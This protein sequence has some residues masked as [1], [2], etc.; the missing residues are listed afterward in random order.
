MPGLRDRLAFYAHRMRQEGLWWAVTR[1]LKRAAYAA[2]WLLLLPLTLL[3]H[4]AGVRRLTVF[5]DRIGHLAAEIDAFLKEQALGRL[6]ARRWFVLAPPHRVANAALLDRWRA[7]LPVIDSP[8]LCLLL[9]IMTWNYW[10]MCRDIR[11]YVL[12][13]PGTAR[14]YEIEAAWGE[15][16]PLLALTPEDHAR[17]R[18][19]LEAMGLPPG[20]DF[21]CVHAREPGFS[22][23]DEILHAHRNADAG[24]LAAAMAWL[25]QQG[26]WCV[27]MG[28]PTAAPLPPMARVIDYAHHPLRSPWLDVYLCAACRLFV[29]SSSGL[30]I[31]AGV[32]GVP[33]AL[34]N[35]APLS[36]AWSYAP[37]DVSM[38]KLLRRSG[39]A[40]PTLREDFASPAADYR[41]AAQYREAGLEL[42]EN[43]EAE[44]LALVQEAWA[45]LQGVWESGDGD[46]ALQTRMHALLR[47]SHYAYGA[48]SRIGA[49]FLRRH[50]ALLD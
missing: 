14:Y 8:A 5:T 6:P 11:D 36:A 9:D 27:R 44:I 7:Q 29:G 30:F 25:T 35:M 47:P 10:L 2:G 3:L 38:P 33:C 40:V 16:P 34:A 13:E 26:V 1:V 50:R 46:E 42:V 45:R 17:G 12:I 49:D 28:G 41:R 19:A 20:A 37:R 39:G 22:P 43:T 21:V 4:A 48:G 31:V 15:R 18:A 24:R 32:F 23:A